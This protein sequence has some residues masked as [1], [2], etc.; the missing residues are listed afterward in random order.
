MNN[1]ASLDG[2]LLRTNVRELDR[3][4]TQNLADVQPEFAALIDYEFTI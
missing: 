2:E 1:G 3:K 4:R